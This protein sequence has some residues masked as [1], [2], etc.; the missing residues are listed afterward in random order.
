MAVAKAE[1]AVVMAMLRVVVRPRAMARLRVVARPREMAASAAK[2]EVAKGS[3]VM[4]D[5]SHA[6]PAVP[7]R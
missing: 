5:R 7:Q 1:I 4:A 6:A 3:G 2:H